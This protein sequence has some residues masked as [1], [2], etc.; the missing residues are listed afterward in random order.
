MYKTHSN[1]ISVV[2][3]R[4]R[5]LYNLI[6]KTIDYR[7]KHNVPFKHAYYCSYKVTY[8]L[9]VYNLIPFHH[10]CLLIYLISY[11]R[12]NSGPHREYS[13]GGP[14]ILILVLYM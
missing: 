4:D 11:I 9:Q 7:E 10:T 3:T 12:I 2:C 14:E 1:T 8:K 6:L 13:C 5:L